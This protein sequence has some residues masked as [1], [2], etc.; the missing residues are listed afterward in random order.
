MFVCR[1]DYKLMLLNSTFCLVPRGRRLGSYRLYRNCVNLLYSRPHLGR[2]TGLARL[3]V[4]LSACLS[5][6]PVRAQLENNK[7]RSNLAKGGSAVASSP[8]SS[9]VFARWQHGIGGLAAV[10]NCMFWL[11]FDPQIFLSLGA[12]GTT[13]NTMCPLTPQVYLPNSI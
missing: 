6:P 12:S 10:C 11:G 4:R 1:W 8:Y 3:S 9:F 5:V 13:S 2:I 7:D